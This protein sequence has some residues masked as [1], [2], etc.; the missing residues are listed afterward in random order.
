MGELRT[1]VRVRAEGLGITAKTLVTF[2][3]LVYDARRNSD[4]EGRLALLAFAFGQLAYSSAVLATY[5]ADAGYVTLL[6]TR[7]YVIK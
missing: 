6:P 5:A 1:I 4:A 7:R 2:L 3:V